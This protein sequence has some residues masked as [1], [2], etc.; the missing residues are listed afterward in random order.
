VTCQQ[1]GATLVFVAV[2]EQVVGAIELQATIRP[3]AQ[4]VIQQLKHRNLSLSIISGDHEEPTRKL[5]AKLGI[6]NY[7]ANTLPE[8][9]A[10]HIKQLQN[11]GRVVCFIGDGINDA[12]ALKQ[13]DVSIS[14]L[15]AT[16]IATDT[17]QIIFMDRSLNQ[18]DHLLALAHQY[19]KTLQT[20]F[21]TSVVPGVVSIAGVFVA[22]FGF[23]A[24]EILFQLGLFSGLG[25]AMQ[26]LLT[27]NN[28][29]HRLTPHHERLTA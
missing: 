3:E 19:E 2:D 20:G 24:V 15:G 8:N 4:R 11:E 16:S 28:Q 12:I 5:A 25:V 17:A 6:Q 1:E 14:L 21:I 26:P 7:F 18:L 23:Y 9:K 27:E 13:A 29:T 22:G 10:Q